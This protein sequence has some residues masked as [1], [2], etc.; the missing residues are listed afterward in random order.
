[1]IRLSAVLRREG[2]R[3]TFDVT[4]QPVDVEVETGPDVSVV[5]VSPI[6]DAL[7]V[8][9]D[10]MVVGQVDRDSVERIEAFSI[11]RGLLESLDVDETTPEGLIALVTAAG[12]GWVRLEVA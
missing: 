9:A 6:P 11:P 12:V 3:I 4:G 1:M 2:E 10:G 7:K 5:V 8:V